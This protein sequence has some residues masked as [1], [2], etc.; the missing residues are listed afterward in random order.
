LV[1]PAALL[2]ATAIVVYGAATIDE[3]TD[4]R[5]LT[6][7]LITGLLW[8]VALWPTP[9]RSARNPDRAIVHLAAVFAVGFLL[10]G[11]QLVRVQALDRERIH[12]RAASPGIEGVTDPRRQVL[13]Q[14]PLRGRILARD[15]TVLAETTMTG[16]GRPKRMYPFAPA[17]YLAGYFS[18]ALYGA[19]NVEHAYDSELSGR[20][21]ARRLQEWID[22][23]LNRSTAGYDVVLTIDP[24]LQSLADQLLAGRAGAVVLLDARSGAV[25][26]MASAPAF[27]PNLLSVGPHATSEELATARA[28]WESLQRSGDGALVLRATQGRYPPGSTFK[29]VTLAAALESGVATL[30]SVY[31]DEGMLVVDSRVIIEQNRPDPDRV[32]FRL[33]EGYGYSLN[34]V[35][36]QLGLELGAGRLSET[37]H[38]F[39]FGESIPFDL[40]VSPSVLSLDPAYLSNTAGLVETAFGQGQLLVTPFQMALVTAAVVRGGDLPVPRLVE[41]IQT[42]RGDVIERHRGESWRRAMSPETAAQ[43]ERAMRW[44]VERGSARAAQIAGAVVGGKTG[45]AEVGDRP[46]HAWFIGF[47]GRDEP[48]FVVAV[49][50][51]NAGSGA[52]IALPIGRALL[53]A[54]LR[55]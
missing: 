47:A 28:Y 33:E 39:G 42:A 21:G 37:A 31:R 26:A 12:R 38:R 23:V 1:R 25:L 48:E 41:R 17:A 55:R 54:A 40:P 49:V 4:P 50:V 19:T 7:L 11:A 15:G 46:P 30:D 27:D 36:A 34:V 52:E 20:T 9:V 24:A 13:A 43:V 45:T 5:W 8:G 32:S 51:E 2:A 22:G 18:P 3:R 44:S 10:V 53:E 14:V 29:T 6:L 35:F 16:D